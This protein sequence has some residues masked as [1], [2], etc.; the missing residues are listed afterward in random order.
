MKKK[1]ERR[2]ISA[3]SFFVHK[4]TTSSTWLAAQGELIIFGSAR[5]NRT[6]DFALRGR[7]LSRLT[8]APLAPGLGLEPRPNDPESLVLPL[9]HPGVFIRTLIIIAKVFMF[10]KINF[11]L[12]M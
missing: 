11:S 6:L 5:G 3:F 9:H 2:D 8:I 1:A 12:V 10:G 7:R 4:K